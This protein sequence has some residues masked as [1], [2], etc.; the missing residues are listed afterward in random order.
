MYKLTYR[1]GNRPLAVSPLTHTGRPPMHQRPGKQGH[2]DGKPKISKPQIS[3]TTMPD[4]IYITTVPGSCVPWWRSSN[5]VGPFH[6]WPS[7]LKNLF[8]AERKHESVT[9][10]ISTYKES[11]VSGHAHLSPVDASQSSV[12][13]HIRKGERRI[14]A[15]RQFHGAG[16]EQTAHH[17]PPLTVGLTPKQRSLS[18][19]LHLPTV[20]S[21]VAPQHSTGGPSL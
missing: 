3:N 16:L 5:S 11:S 14:A 1:K 6:S 19:P 13:T 20:A 12:D 15:M 2:G 21:H 4:K 18:P 9:P 17:P 8:Q 7:Q 10:H